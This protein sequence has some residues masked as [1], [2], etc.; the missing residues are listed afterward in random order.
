MSNR[1]SD[2]EYVAKHDGKNQAKSFLLKFYLSNEREKRLYE[3]LQNQDNKK[4][5]I[6]DLIDNHKPR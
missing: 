2:S 6:L 1:K 4:Q 3:F 5:F